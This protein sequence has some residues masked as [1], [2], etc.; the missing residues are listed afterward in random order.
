[1]GKIELAQLRI[2]SDN[3]K[4][5]VLYEP[6]PVRTFNVII[7]SLEISVGNY[8]FIDYGSGKGRTLIAAAEVGFRRVIGIEFSPKL[9]D[10]A[11]RNLSTYSRKRGRDANAEIY[12]V[13]AVNFEIPPV[14]AVL[15]FFNPFEREVL[16]RVV[17]N[18]RRSYE[19]KPRRL[20]VVHY[21]PANTDLFASLN[22]MKKLNARSTVLEFAGPSGR[23]YAC[24]GTR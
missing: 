14:P 11:K 8:T 23:E 5:G 20:Y 13:D 4:H 12:C 15:Y 3:K 1:M 21:N 7:R 10:V 6:T 17:Q 18:I 2:D 9:C 22:F 16:E 19:A 24:Y